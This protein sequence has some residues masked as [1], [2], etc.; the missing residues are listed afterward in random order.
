MKLLPLLATV[1]MMLTC[2]AFLGRNQANISQA[3]IISPFMK[4]CLRGEGRLEPE[5]T[6]EQDHTYF[7]ILNYGGFIGGIDSSAPCEEKAPYFEALTHIELDSSNIVDVSPIATLRNLESISLGSNPIP[8]IPGLWALA[9]L[10][11][12]YGLSASGIGDWLTC[13][14]ADIDCTF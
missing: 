10:P 5:L 8:R 7:A 4:L 2:D 6:K 1:T 14:R 3:G 13:P 12:L 11:K 9:S